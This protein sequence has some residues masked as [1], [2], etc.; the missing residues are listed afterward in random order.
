VRIRSLD[1]LRQADERTLRF[2]SLGFDTGGMLRPE[3]A[4]I[5]QQESLSHA[6]LSA[7]VAEG[8]NVGPILITWR[9][10]NVD[11]LTVGFVVV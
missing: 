4:T 2:T 11:P 5:Y 10:L 8:V 7:A 1:E 3:D 9:R 6:E